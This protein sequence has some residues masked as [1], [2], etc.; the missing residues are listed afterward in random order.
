MLPAKV[1]SFAWQIRFLIPLQYG[2]GI[3][4]IGNALHFLYI[5]AIQAGGCHGGAKLYVFVRQQALEFRCIAFTC[6]QQTF[7]KSHALYEAVYYLYFSL[8]YRTELVHANLSLPKKHSIVVAAM[9]SQTP[10]RSVFSFTCKTFSKAHS[11]VVLLCNKP[12][13]SYLASLY[14]Q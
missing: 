9:L 10:R 7:S 4:Y 13:A 6:C 1:S 2:M 12:K 8:R 5:I 14:L 3:T 11:V